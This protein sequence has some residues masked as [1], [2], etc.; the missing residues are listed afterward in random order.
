VI[1]EVDRMLDIGFLPVLL[2]IQSYM[3]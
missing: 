3:P 1:D 2:R